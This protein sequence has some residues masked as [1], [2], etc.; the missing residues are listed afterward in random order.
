[1]VQIQQPNIE[2][3]GTF[4]N[5]TK[6][7]QIRLRGEALFPWLEKGKQPDLYI[8]R[9]RH[10]IYYSAVESAGARRILID[11]TVP[12]E[13][14][15]NSISIHARVGNNLIYK[16]EVVVFRHPLEEKR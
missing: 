4:A 2:L 14:G 6:G 15:P 5:Q 1:M 12:L 13:V 10:K 16:K 8:F 11:A 3:T 9:G 7:K